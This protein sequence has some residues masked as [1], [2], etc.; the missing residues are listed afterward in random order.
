M[1]LLYLGLLIAGYKTLKNRSTTPLTRATAF[2]HREYTS[3][4][5]W[6]E[7]FFLVQRLT[8]VGFVQLVSP[9]R[10]YARFS[11]GSAPY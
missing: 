10:F 5:V 4:T 8:I 11:V 9:Q 6:W 1:P 2:L 7:P 3:D